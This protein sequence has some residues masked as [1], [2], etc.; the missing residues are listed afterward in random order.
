MH[1]DYLTRLLSF[2]EK[3]LPDLDEVV[4][5]ALS[6]LEAL[7]LPRINVQAHT[8]PLIVGSGNGLH[9]GAI[10]FRYVDAV[11]VNEGSYR[12]VLAR[13]VFDSLYI[14]SA[15]GS[16]HAQE[17]AA[18]AMTLSIPAYL[19]TSTEDSPAG[20]LI[21]REHTFVYP[22]IREPYTYNTSTYLAMLY[23]NT[24]VSPRRARTY[25]E[26]VVQPLMPDFSSY[27]SFLMTIPPQFKEVGAMFEIKFDE[28]FGPYVLGRACTTEELKH[29]KTVVTS[30]TQCLISFGSE[31]SVGDFGCRVT[32]PLQHDMTHSDIIALGYFIIGRIQKSRQPYFKERIGTYV[33]EAGEM[34]GQ[35]LP[36]IVS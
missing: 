24:E 8:R 13:G 22:H 35:E 34:F 36:V 31:I 20:A 30:S 29:A 4:M 32:V 21:G 16:K 11:C 18:Y 25:I 19:I 10:L 9:T 17:I 2:T 1:I 26:T 5:G 3:D 15:S 28:L 7:D 6:F 33:K 14:I 12:D 27:T 23:G